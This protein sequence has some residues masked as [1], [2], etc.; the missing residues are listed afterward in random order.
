MA[1]IIVTGTSRGIGEALAQRLLELGHRVIGISRS[2]GEDG[3]AKQDGR[4]VRL[5]ADLAETDRLEALMARVFET[6]PNDGSADVYLVN[7]AAVLQPLANVGAAGTAEVERHVRVNLTAPMVL[8]AAFAKHTQQWTSDR[9][10]L[11]VSSAS[12]SILLPGMSAYC[13]VKAGLDVFSKVMGMEQ[14]Q[15][16]SPIKVASVW[17]GMIDT[18]MQ[19]EIRGQDPAVFPSAEVFIGAK[20]GGMLTTPEQT[21]AK[22]ADLLTRPDFPQGEVLTEL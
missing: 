11:N 8:A 5:A 1:Y 7:N 12:A 3:A 17:P 4:Y 10:I 9:R 22:L 16:P 6:I 2:G 18:A 13:A 20:Q 14:A 15:Q 21:G 19:A